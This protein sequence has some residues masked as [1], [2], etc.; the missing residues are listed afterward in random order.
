MAEARRI[1]MISGPRNISTALMRSQGSRPDTVVCDEP[2]YAYFLAQTSGHAEGRHP[3]IEEVL[4]YHETD[5]P[6][7][8]QHLTQ[9]PLPLAAMIF[10]PKGTRQ[11][12]REK[13]P[14]GANI[15]Y[16]KHMAHHFIP[17]VER[18][19]LLDRVTTCFLIRNPRE[20]VGSLLRTQ[21]KLRDSLAVGV[22]DTGLP[23]QVELFDYVR[24]GTG[25]VPPVLDAGD[26]L[27]NPEGVLGAFCDRIKVPYIP[28]ML[29][30]E[31][32][33]AY[34]DGIWAKYW[35]NSVMNSTGFGTYQDKD[36]KLPPELEPV[37]IE[38]NELYQV[39]YS[40]RI[41]AAV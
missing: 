13:I 11:A 16:Q 37:V 26:V 21:P 29:S 9:E 39:L 38:A 31:S 23:E 2:L 6:I 4:A 14:P 24:Q 32:G 41:T 8:L 10:Y 17:G 1:A 27:A 19:W 40:H 3:G 22:A 5:L 28:A 33:L 15:F 25:Q 36:E 35:Y 7:V 34:Y 12:A 18:G 30:W 20:V